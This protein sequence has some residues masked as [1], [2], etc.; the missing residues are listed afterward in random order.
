MHEWPQRH[1]ITVEHFY[2]M[3]EAGLFDDSAR[4]ELVNGEI[5]DVPPMGSRHASTV[6]RIAAALSTVFGERAM[7]RQQLPLRLS[8]DSEP[9]PDI[10]VVVPR[11]DDYASAHPT[12]SDTWLVVE[13]SDST[14]RYD[15]EVK[16]G[17]YARSNVPEV[18]VVDLQADRVHLYRSPRNAEYGVVETVGFGKLSVGALAGVEIDLGPLRA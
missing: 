10:A 1:R 11:A 15:R 2:R 12:A 7:V 9:L 16:T 8:V 18:W 4:V 6:H 17:L 14:L 13:V 5:I 3:A